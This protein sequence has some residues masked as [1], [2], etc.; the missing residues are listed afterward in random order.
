MENKHSFCLV[1]GKE[2]IKL[3]S[4]YRGYLIF[5]KRE[6]IFV[7]IDHD[8]IKKITN[9]EPCAKRL[10]IFYSKEFS[11]VEFV[12]EEKVYQIVFGYSDKVLIIS[13]PDRKEVIEVYGTLI[14]LP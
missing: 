4:G 13:Y 7:D 11:K 6:L 10:Y 12:K 2:L 3:L 5:G 9:C 1:T 14:P 8:K